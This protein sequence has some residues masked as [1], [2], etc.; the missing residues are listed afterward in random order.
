LGVQC[1]RSD[2]GFCRQWE[3]VGD[4]IR[5]VSNFGRAVEENPRLATSTYS[6]GFGNFIQ[7]PNLSS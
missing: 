6:F 3:V 7:L 2:V 1:I 4:E 5:M